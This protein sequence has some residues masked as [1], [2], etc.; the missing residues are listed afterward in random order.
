MIIVRPRE[1]ETADQTT[2]ANLEKTAPYPSSRGCCSTLS[3]HPSALDLPT[4]MSKT[5]VKKLNQK[6]L[7][8]DEEDSEEI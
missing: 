7:R 5:Y 2:E 1:T 3:T 4:A 8:S 6:Y